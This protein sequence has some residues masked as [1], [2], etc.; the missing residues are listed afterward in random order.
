MVVLLLEEEEEEKTFFG[1]SNGTSLAL[2]ES[3][4]HL[5]NFCLFQKKKARNFWKKE[6]EKKLR[7]TTT[8]FLMIIDIQVR[9]RCERHFVYFFFSSSPHPE[10]R[11]TT[12]SMRKK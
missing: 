3:Y 2:R 8:N 11:N 12:K 10:L 7:P 9:V 4:F 1:M 6:F 5:P